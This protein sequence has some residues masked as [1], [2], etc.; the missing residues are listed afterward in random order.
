MLRRDNRLL[1]A[2]RASWNAPNEACP[3]IIRKDCLQF[4]WSWTSIANAG[5]RRD[6]RAE[7]RSGDVAVTIDGEPV[8]IRARRKP[9]AVNPGEHRLRFSRGERRES[10]ALSIVARES[11]KGRRVVAE[12]APAQRSL[13]RPKPA[14]RESTLMSAEPWVL[15][16]VGALRLWVIR[17]LRAQGSTRPK[18]ISNNARRRVSEDD[19]DRMRGAVSGGRH[20]ARDRAR[21][22]GRCDVSVRLAALDASSARSQ[23]V[24][25]FTSAGHLRDRAAGDQMHGN[26]SFLTFRCL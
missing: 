12:F 9:V 10:R 6:R 1:E 19:V 8:D 20:L 22:A 11:E 14:E 3:S 15:G 4:V 13:S 24:R 26:A 21:V 18:A 17:L 2:R 5:V 16:G 7:A 23:R 25:Q